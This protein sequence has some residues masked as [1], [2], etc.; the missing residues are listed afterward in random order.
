MLVIT[1][2]NIIV[3]LK[4]QKTPGLVAAAFRPQLP[5]DIQ[6]KPNQTLF[7]FQYQWVLQSI[8]LYICNYLITYKFNMKLHVEQDPMPGVDLNPTPSKK[9][10]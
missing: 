2:N 8:I 9:N 6:L 7:L 5:P 10:I 4:N 3:C 1:A